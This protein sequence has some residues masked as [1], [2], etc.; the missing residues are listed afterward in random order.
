MNFKAKLFNSINKFSH[1]KSFHFDIHPYVD[2][3]KFKNCDNIISIGVNMK[4][5]LTE[6][7][8]LEKKIEKYGFWRHAYIL[9]LMGSTILT[10][11]AAVISFIV[12]L[13]TG[14]FAVTGILAIIAFI[15]CSASVAGYKLSDAIDEKFYTKLLDLRNKLD[16]LNINELSYVENFEI[17]NT[18]TNSIT[19][20]KTTQQSK[21]HTI[22]NEDE[23][24]LGL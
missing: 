12:S 15:S 23:N 21:N 7:E 2:I 16:N 18:Q 4:N 13:C 22:E 17:N 19:C 11:T 9:A 14:S 24:N 10:S 5:K 6:K 1:K 3:D 8:K 20:N